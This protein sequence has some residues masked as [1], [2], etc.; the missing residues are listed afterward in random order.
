MNWARN[1]L[2]GRIALQSAATA[3]FIWNINQDTN[4]PFSDAV[5]FIWFAGE[6]A[7][8]WNPILKPAAIGTALRM[9]AGS[10][11]VSTVLAPVAAGVAI[12]ATAGTAI[13]G[14]I[15]GEEG[16]QTALGFYSAG[17]L[18]GTEPPTL[19]DYQYIFRPT[20]PGG[21]VSAY[22]VAEAGVRGT[23]RGLGWLWGKRPQMYTHPSPYMI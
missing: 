1:I 13:S 10:T 22:D 12:G 15:W 3:R 11:L 16:A 8:I 4:D 18:P 5:D 6:S 14:A 21:P 7:L 20:A 19:T 2:V 23:A 17:T 9:S